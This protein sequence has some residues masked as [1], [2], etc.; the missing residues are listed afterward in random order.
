MEVLREAM[1]AGGGGQQQTRAVRLA[2]W[3]LRRHCPL[4]W[5][6][7]FWDAAGG[8]EPIGRGQGLNAAYNGI[9]RH[10]RTR[11]AIRW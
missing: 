9:V 5:L 2:L 10:L 1:Q 3:A 6:R 11:G 4:A 7:Q 8:P